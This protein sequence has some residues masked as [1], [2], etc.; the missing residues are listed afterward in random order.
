[1]PAH[2]IRSLLGDSAQFETL[3]D[4]MRRLQALQQAYVGSIPVELATASRVGYIRA[5]TLYVIA[6]NSAVAAKLR[7]LAPRAVPVVQKLRPEIT[8][9]QILTQA[10]KDSGIPPAHAK[11]EPLSIDNIELFEILAKSVTD[12]QL[13][14][15]LTRFAQRAQRLR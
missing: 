14:S 11:K 10:K 3:L 8:G 1:M 9:I 13:K 15:A 5:N 12:P 2:N 6:D 7:Q 4:N